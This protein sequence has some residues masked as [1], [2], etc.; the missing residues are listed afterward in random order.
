[1]SGGDEC[2]PKLRTLAEPL[3]LDM[4]RLLAAGP[5]SI[6]EVAA[7]LQIPHYQAS[8][9][10]AALAALGVVAQRRRGRVVENHLSQQAPDLDLGCCTLRLAPPEG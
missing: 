6:G 7:A 10:L 1:V 8:R 5:R 2:A 9:H 4:L 3:R